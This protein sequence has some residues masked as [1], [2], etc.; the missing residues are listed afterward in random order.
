MKCLPALLALLVTCLYSSAVAQT[1]VIVPATTTTISVTGTVAASTQIIA[2]ITGQRI[3]ITNISLTPVA[4]SV[5]T[6]TS[7][8]GTNCG[9]GTTSLTGAQ[10][11]TTGQTYR[12]GTGNG[13][14]L[15]T[16]AGHS[17]CITIATAVAPGSIAYAQF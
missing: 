3:Y 10:T 7:G 11:F 14:V 9:T 8:T 1:S 17:L 5:V 4:T 13:A 15:V 16:A 6:L 12:V 2:G